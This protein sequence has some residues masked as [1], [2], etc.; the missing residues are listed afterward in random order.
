MVDMATI[1]PAARAFIET[2]PF[3]HVI[4]LDPDGTPYVTLAWI[5]VEGDDL[6]WSTF[7]DQRKVENLRRDP[8]ITISFQAR[9]TDGGFLYPYLVATGTATISEGG[10]MEIM[11][12]LAPAYM[13]ADRFPNRDMPPGLTIGVRVDKVYVTGTWREAPPE[14]AEA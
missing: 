2:G 14:R 6:V 9:E 13:G 4:T 7:F 11:D 8:R 1:T 5:A 12:R 3:G 10:A